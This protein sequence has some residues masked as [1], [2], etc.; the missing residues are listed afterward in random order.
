MI[1]AFIVACI[2]LS[3]ILIYTGNNVQTNTIFNYDFPIW[4]GI[5]LF[6][7]Y[8]WILGINLHHW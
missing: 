6:I 1:G 5:G 3:G 8:I 2:F 7:I 4:R